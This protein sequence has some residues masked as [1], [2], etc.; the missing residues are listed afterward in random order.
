MYLVC[1]LLAATGCNRDKP[2]E[3]VQEPSGR[4]TGIGGLLKDGEGQDVVLEEMA[5]REFIPVDTVT[6]N[7]QGE[8]HISFKSDRVAFYVLRTGS[9]GYITLL[10]EPGEKIEYSGAYGQTNQYTVKGSEGSELLMVLAQEHKR[11]L[12][13]L[14]RIT[15]KNMELQ[16]TSGYAQLKEDL[17]RQ[18]DSITAIFHDYSLDFIDRNQESL[19]ILIALYNLYGQ[20]LPVFHPEGDIEVYQ[21]VDS[22][23]TPAYGD[24][25]VVRLLH[26]QVLGAQLPEDQAAQVRGPE[27]G[28][29]APDFVSSRPDEDRMA[30]S[31]LKGKTVLLSFWAG[32]SKLSREE[33]RYLKE[34]WATHGTQPFRILQVSFDDDPAVWLRAIEEEGLN[35]DHVS[36]LR[37]WETVVADLYGVEKIPAN[38]LIDPEG[39]IIGRDLF[40]NELTEYLENLYGKE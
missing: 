12:D 5:A 3:A 24:L 8:F 7:G 31:D 30:L 26:A 35:W 27:I 17:D 11:T 38:F 16:A 39:R 23:L 1:A 40:G 6:C 20:G 10:M 19:A 29:I 32:W 15:R 2:S 13:A 28:E 22:V 25:E 4:K 9:S 21:F 34:A 14:G 33:N 18:F 36:D 37:R